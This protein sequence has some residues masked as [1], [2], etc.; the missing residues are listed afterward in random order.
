MEGR[1]MKKAKIKQ[2]SPSVLGRGFVGVDLE[3][4]T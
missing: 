4:V 3:D 2:Q 1:T